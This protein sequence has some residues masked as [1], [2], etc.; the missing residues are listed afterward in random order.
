MNNP[1]FKNNGPYKID[2]LLKLSG[3]K[4]INKF[5]NLKV[6]DI[7]DLSTSTDK[8]ITFFHSKKYSD[9][10]L[11]T[12]ASFCITSANLKNY[13]PTNCQ[14]IIVDKVLIST[15]KITKT[16]YPDSVTDD[17]DT[18]VKEINK[19]SFKKIIKFGKTVLIGKSAVIKGD[20]FFKR[21]LKTEEVA[22]IDG[23][24]KRTNNGK[25]NTEEDIAIEEI[26]DRSE[27]GRPKVVP[28]ATHKEAV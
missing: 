26:V 11:K 27:A 14:K 25:A 21:T 10:A 20:V 16:L 5:N 7:K 15:A 4:I 13:L 23:Y 18:S 22:D 17:F 6:Y 12:K 1:F 24:I 9:I 28:V 19:T 2:K 8:D 3:I